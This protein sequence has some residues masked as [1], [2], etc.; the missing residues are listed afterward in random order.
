[1]EPF[2]VR[3]EISESQYAKLMALKYIKSAVYIYVLAATILVWAI[4]IYKSESGWSTYFYT[5][6]TILIGLPLVAWGS[7]IALYR[8]S[9]V[10]DGVNYTIDLDGIAAEAEGV[11]TKVGWKHI[12]DSKQV[13]GY[14]LLYHFRSVLCIL[15]VSSLTPEQIIFIRQKIK[16][17]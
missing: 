7:A 2:T 15:P 1:M 4:D 9:V 12:S 13:M 11:N 10:K 16:G 6:I 5:G 14:L 8:K 3:V 17:K